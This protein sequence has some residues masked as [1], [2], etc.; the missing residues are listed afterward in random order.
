MGWG[1]NAQ[2]KAGASKQKQRHPNMMIAVWRVKK[3][4][5]DM[6]RQTSW[7]YSMGR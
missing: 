1:Q 5:G 6:P 2:H 7:N 3:G 4:H